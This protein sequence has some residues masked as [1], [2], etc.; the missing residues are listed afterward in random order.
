[1][2]KTAPGEDSKK[3]SPEVI[4]SACT[5]QPLD[6]AFVEHGPTGNYMWMYIGIATGVQR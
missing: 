2:V 5:F 3:L 6:E 4:E 1:M